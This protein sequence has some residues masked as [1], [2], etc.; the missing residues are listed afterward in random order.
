MV[1]ALEDKRYDVLFKRGQVLIYPRGILA[2]SAREIGVRHAKVYKFSF[3]P[4]MAL[5]SNTRDRTDSSSSSSELFEIWH[6]KMGHMYHGALST[7]RE[8]TTDVLDFSS[9]YLDVSKRCAMGKF[10]RSPF[11]SNDSK[12][13]VILDLI[14]NDVSG[15]MSHVSLSG[16]EYYVLF[17][18]DH[19]RKP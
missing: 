16:Y 1:S 8:I 19:S 17:I 15:C 9:K 4:L 11:P 10:A 2:S 5:S 6:R 14:H 18:D 3:Q 7:L 13:T 12:A